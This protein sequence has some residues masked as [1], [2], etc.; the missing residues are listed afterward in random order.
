MSVLLS[1]WGCTVVTGQTSGEVMESYAAKKTEPAV[2][3]VDYHLDRGS[4]ID[5]IADLRRHF[6]ARLPAALVTA[7]RSPT[8][9][10]EAA[11][12]AIAIINKPVRPGALR[13]LVAQLHAQRTAA[14]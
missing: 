9:R 12:S 2:V 4:G 14:E 11:S 7:D 3:L 6:G 1:G 8:L 5:A 10:A 13:A